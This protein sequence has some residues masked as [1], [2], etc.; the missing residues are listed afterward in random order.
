MSFKRES[1]ASITVFLTILFLLFFSM[2][3]VMLDSARV[4]AS[5]GYFRVAS[6]SAAM[7]VFGNYNKELYEQYGFFAYG[8]YDGIDAEDL[9]MEFLEILEKNLAA[10]PEGQERFYGDLYRFSEVASEVMETGTLMEKK[11]FYEQVRGFLKRQAVKKVFGKTTEKIP[12]N[13]TSAKEK[14]EIT[15]DY[16]HGK[17]D[18][19]KEDG[20]GENAESTDAAGEESSAESTTES[21]VPD[22]AGGNPLSVF[23]EMMGNGIL[24]LVC[25]ETN[26]SELEIP[27]REESGQDLEGKKQETT[28]EGEER[29]AADYL[30]E[31]MEQDSTDHIHKMQELKNESTGGTGM[32]EKTEL[33]LYALEQLSDYT[34]PLDKTAKY[35][36]EYLIAGKEKENRNLSY[37][38]NRILAMRLVLNLA[39]VISS[40]ELQEKSLATATVLAGFTGL[41]PVISAVQYTILMILAFEES[42]VDVTALLEGRAVPVLKNATNFKMK[43]EEICICSRAL[44][45]KKASSYPAAKK[46]NTSGIGY[47]EYLYLLFLLQKEEVLRSRTGDLIQFDLRTRYNQTFTIHTCICSAYYKLEYQNGALFSSLPFLSGDNWSFGRKNQEVFYEY[48][49]K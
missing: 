30:S 5:D 49:S 13:T 16:E 21:T 18:E 37:V 1:G 47:H 31:L 35:G 36:L 29:G 38:V 17:Y 34:K 26:I 44:F 11:V 9:N 23:S 46:I 41:P 10:A 4:L 2:T 6:R 14:L 22:T 12:E 27:K 24:S 8:G 3:G 28:A 45:Q 42:C 20:S 43:Y 25:D 15:K 40:P 39:Y 7:T 19:L 33:F 32:S 48:K